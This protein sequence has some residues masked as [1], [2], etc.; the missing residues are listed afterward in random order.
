VLGISAAIGLKH[1]LLITKLKIQPFVVTLCSLLLYRGVARFAANDQPI[2]FGS[3]FGGLKY[4][5]EGE[6]FSIP[7]PFLPL[8]SQA[9]GEGEGSSPPLVEWIGVPMPAIMLAVVALVAILFLNYSVFGRYL[10]ALGR[11]EQAARFSGINTDRLVIAAYVICAMLAGLTGMLAALE[12]N[13]V[14]PGSTGNLFELYAI[15]AAVL[16]GCSLRGG[17]GTI[18]GVIAGAAVMQVL[19]NSINLTGVKDQLEYV[20]IGTVILGGVMVDEVVKRYVAKRRARREA[21]SHGV[22]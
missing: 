4:F 22:R 6:P 7:V 14:Q 19:A 10:L 3:A 17:E 11:N 21:A 2:G 16:G 1:G 20:V 12:V 9:A 18:V 15:A 8:I 5:A 13:S